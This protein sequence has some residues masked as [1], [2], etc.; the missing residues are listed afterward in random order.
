[1]SQGVLLLHD[2]A[3]TYSPA[4]SEEI[5]QELKSEALDHPPYS[6]DMAPSDFHLFGLLKE[7]FR[8]RRFVDDDEM[9][10]A[11]YDWLRNQPKFFMVPV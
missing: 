11:V 9:K 2:N 8:S 4:H 3:S 6:P 10:K 5:L 1:L 7:A